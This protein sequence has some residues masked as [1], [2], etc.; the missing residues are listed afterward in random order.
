M[1]SEAEN[2]VFA[3][4]LEAA[5]FDTE[6]GRLRAAIAK[7][8]AGKSDFEARSALWI[9]LTKDKA[10]AGVAMGALMAICWPS[11]NIPVIPKLKGR[12]MPDAAALV[13]R[14]AVVLATAKSLVRVRAAV[15]EKTVKDRLCWSDG[16]LV[17]NSNMSDLIARERS[18]IYDSSLARI[19]R[20]ACKGISDRKLTV[21]KVLTDKDLER[22]D[23]AAKE[24]TRT[25]FAA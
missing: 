1:F 4:K 12:V 2:N 14:E 21:G 22:C 5:G 23:A 19:L 15:I 9:Y 24:T 25:A 6:L 7:A 17:A 20:S 10:M 13:R 18:G 3:D 11:A 16:S 8:T